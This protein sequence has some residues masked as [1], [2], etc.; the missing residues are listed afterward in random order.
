M[1]NNGN[2]LVQMANVLNMLAPHNVLRQ[3]MA[4]A[5]LPMMPMGVPETPAKAPTEQQN[6]PAG[7]E[8]R[9]AKR[10]G[11]SVEELKAKRAED[12]VKSERAGFS[13]Q[14]NTIIF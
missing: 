12:R 11:V 6:Y 8:E 1:N 14:G 10:T 13:V 4:G 3:M 9:W 7:I 5:Q 2:P